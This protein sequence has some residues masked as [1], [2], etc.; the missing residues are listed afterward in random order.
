MGRLLRSGDGWRIGWDPDA[1]TYRGL[2]GGDGWALEL[3]ETELNEFC[4]L[5]E[6]MVAAISSMAEELMEQERI[7]CELESEWLWLEA[8]GYPHHYSL[9]CILQ[10][11]RRG[12]GSWSPSAVPALVQ[13][14]RTLTVF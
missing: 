4:R 10:T 5:L 14:A 13:A 11:G 2:I 7:D 9:R 8:E 1:P 3:S 12:E 6:Q